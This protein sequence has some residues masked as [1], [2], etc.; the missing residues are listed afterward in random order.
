M[1]TTVFNFNVSNAKCS[2]INKIGLHL[3]IF[4]TRSF[5]PQEIQDRLFDSDD[6]KIIIL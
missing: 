3:V 1:K 2:L 4:Q 6:F 5:V